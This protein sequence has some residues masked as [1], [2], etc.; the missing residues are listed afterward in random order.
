MYA[1]KK[2][3][4]LRSISDVDLIAFYRL[5]SAIPLLKR[6]LLALPDE[7][8]VAITFPDEGAW[9]RFHLAFPDRWPTITCTKVR[10]GQ[11]R[12]VSIKEGEKCIITVVWG[13]SWGRVYVHYGCSEE[14][15]VS[16]IFVLRQHF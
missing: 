14:S 6:E 16:I 13:W 9:K 12:E 2:F 4:P 11:E 1:K 3:F 5:L 8:N 15:K 7:S 10:H